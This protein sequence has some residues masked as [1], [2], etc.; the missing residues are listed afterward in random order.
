MATKK[1]KRKPPSPAPQT[2]FNGS[3]YS[4]FA[5]GKRD[6]SDYTDLR[7]ETFQRQQAATLGM[8][9]M[10]GGVGVPG[11]VGVTGVTSTGE[12]D[13]RQFGELAP[14]ERPN[15]SPIDQEVPEK[16]KDN[17][18]L[19]GFLDFM[20]NIVPDDMGGLL[21]GRSDQ[22]LPEVPYVSDIYRNTVGRFVGAG[23]DIGAG[24][25]D[26][27]NWGSDQMN[28]LGAALASA[29]PGGIQTLDW[30]QAQ[31]ISMGQVVSANYA[32]NQR[33]GITGQLINIP[34]SGIIG[35]L[36]NVQ[37]MIDPDNIIFSNQFNIL[38]PEIR[39]E[40]FES[41]GLGQFTSGFTDAVWTVGADPLI[42]GGPISSVARFGTKAGKFSGYTNRSLNN[43]VQIDRFGED[44][45]YQ[46]RVL[47]E[48]A[49]QALETGE[50]FLQVA[51]SS[52]RLSSDGEYL[53]AAMQGKA[54]ELF[55]HPYVRGSSD[56]RA[57]QSLLGETTLERPEEAAA[58]VGALAGHAGSWGRL[59]TLN[60]E[61]YE[62][63][64]M[65]LGIDPFAP[66]GSSLNDFA[67][68][69]IKLTPEQRILG[70]DIVY[71]RLSQRPDLVEDLAATGQLIR[72]AGAGIG[73]RTVR[74]KNAWRA[75]AARQQFSRRPGSPVTSSTDRP[76]Q[77]HFV[78]D[79]IYGVAGSA[80]LRVVRWMGQGTPNGVVQLKDGSDAMNSLDEFAAWLRKSPMDADTSRGF[81]NAFASAR[82]VA[83]RKAVL[84]NAENSMIDAIVLASGGKMTAQA[85]RNAYR[86]YNSRRAAVL[87]EARSTET[88]FAIDPTT[89]EKVLLPG[90]YAELDQAFPLLD[91][92]EFTR[93]VN[94]NA[95]S[96]AL[97]EA[98]DAANYANSLWKI[99]VLARLGYTQR[100]I[101]E[102]ALRS[103]AVLGVMAI[104][105]KT[106]TN[107]PSNAKYVARV[108]RGAKRVKAEEKMLMDAQKE[109]ADLRLTI[110]TLDKETKDLFGNVT[111][112][113]DELGQLGLR[114]D[115]L[116]S[117]I[118][119]LS[120]SI[121]RS[122]RG[123]REA[124][125][126]RWRVGRRGNVM[127]DG[128]VMRGAFEGQEGS[129]ALKASSA[130][131]TTY[132]TFSSLVARRYDKLSRSPAFRELDPAKLT[133]KQMPEYWAEYATRLMFRYQSDRLGRMILSDVPVDDI[134]R[135][136]TR[137]ENS[138]YLRQMSKATGRDLETKQGLRS[139]IDEQ[140]AR[141][142]NE[143]P[144]GSPLRKKL[145]DGEEIVPADVSAA[146]AGR[147]LP[148]IP[149]RLD[150]GMPV[151]GIFQRGKS[152]LDK[153][154]STIMRWL[155]TIPEDK[156]LRHP[157]YDTVYR[158]E[159]VRLYELA[160]Q[161]GIDMTS[162]FVLNR[163]NRASHRVALKAT[164]ETMYTIDRLSNAAVM[165]RFISPFFPAW[166]NAIRTWGRIVWTNPAVLGA[167]N[168][169]WNIPNSMGMVVDKD[170]NRVDE[171]G[172]PLRSSFLRDEGH[173]I[174]WPKAVTD[175][176]NDK[177]GP[178]APGQEMMT[179]QAGANVIFPGSHWLSPGV[180]L[181]GTIPTALF[182]RGKP[183]DA[184]LLKNVLGEEKFNEIAPMGQ[185]RGNL[186][187]IVLPT[188]G[189]RFR[190]WLAG[191]S[192]ESAYLNTW[193]TIIEDAYIDSQLE[194]RPLTQKDIE[195]VENRAN[196]FW[197]WQV[198]AAATMGVQSSM[199][200]KYQ[201]QRDMWQKLLDDN[202]LTYQQKIKA[203][204]ESFND[205]EFDDPMFGK[206]E[207]FLSITRT[208]SYNETKLQ[209]NLTTWARI[210]K[211]K[212][213]VNELYAINPELVG[214]FGNMGS[215]DDPFSYAVY[216]EYGSTKIGPGG[217]VIR[218]KL[219]P[220]EIIRNNEIADGWREWWKIKDFAEQK[221]IELGYSSLQVDAAQPIRD[222][223][224][225]AE[226]D[227]G[228]R[229]K[230]WGEEKGNYDNN[231]GDFLRGARKIVENK[232]IM[233]EDSTIQVLAAY[234]DMRD[235][236]ADR[237]KNEKN[238]DNRKRIK[239][240][241]YA[242][243]FKMRQLDVGFADFYDQ[244]LDKDDFRRI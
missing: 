160:S 167:G 149:G 170:G 73:P 139:Y 181:P 117:K 8:A 206:G 143:V 69:G 25:M 17:S 125:S 152:G 165:L 72:R 81:F 216:G 130:D 106:L 228:E 150:D 124:E 74:A 203:F 230:A 244:Y 48:A 99:S 163:I 90:F 174:V 189:R 27:L 177:L 153:T 201:I 214:M 209:P 54:D 4:V 37:Q 172:K 159:Q 182:L 188:V 32:I 71:E 127:Y 111:K 31:E 134:M 122:L 95:I 10:A 218:R 65:S 116:I 57:T 144:A 36:I 91:V 183:E 75:G 229:Y 20:D 221:A 18:I 140:I 146:F 85:A 83:E 137:A 109:L 138:G 236:I 62:A 86:G 162:D 108:R 3:S 196:R 87:D 179:R 195:E 64:A 22:W 34:T 82:T 178:F 186:A 40:A 26:V 14:I 128:T 114:E 113:L 1:K 142:S 46:G 241:G 215:F 205:L 2:S 15:V 61:M 156:L 242:A 210:T 220:S 135:Q 217:T 185:V 126:R 89:R 12:L 107:L 237:L 13:P 60:G 145:L 45:Q 76:G 53:I 119:D 84:L 92:K 147:E 212:D 28:H 100:N 78:Y 213:L 223:L 168:I 55:A 41:G 24:T 23:L 227:L 187:D 198:G 50:D 200:S 148:I 38:D 207:A 154:T 68:A 39:E 158:K 131:L 79:M 7:Q 35:P 194:D 103:F 110:K 43:S 232:E 105:P 19:G 77:G 16:N 197:A 123:I 70:D 233:E 94:D 101:A 190:Q 222:I 238:S 56:K 58:L 51:R 136:M 80:P 121:E 133:P 93:V 118:D 33:M 193:N 151:K 226:K 211:N 52:G 235:D 132:M 112:Q 29:M 30:Q 231:F 234:L 184:E 63:A 169:L 171:E 224:E 5:S 173:Y 120:E 11:G 199:R 88:T 42:I 104:N 44:V 9:P 240:I 161:R 180:G 141:L 176:L 191:E 239:Q 49:E 175:F 225:K 115:V 166:E 98:G 219:R 21:R 157:F 208:G 155:G 192:E 47:A 66:L 243:A 6:L 202:S 129:L 102:G 96:F 164:R 67:T 204:V 59:R 97:G